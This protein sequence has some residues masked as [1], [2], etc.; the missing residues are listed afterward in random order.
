MCSKLDS[1]RHEQKLRKSP[2]K[3][4]IDPEKFELSSSMSNESSDTKRN[5]NSRISE[6]NEEMLLPNEAAWLSGD[7]SE[8]GPNETEDVMCRNLKPKQ[9]KLPRFYSD[10][11]DFPEFWAIFE[12]LVHKNKVL[13][14]IE[15]MLLIKDSLKGKTDI[16][17]KGIQLVPKNYVWLIEALKKKYGN[18]PINRAKVVQKL[19]DSCE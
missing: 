8:N 14:T 12:T 1:Q 6:A 18:K 7:H 5:A 9:L 19:V 13:S 2:Q 15:K 4:G 3:L 11:E 17:F 16:A 10:E